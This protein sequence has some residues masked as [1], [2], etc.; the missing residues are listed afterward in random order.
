MPFMYYGYGFV[1]IGFLIALLAQWNVQ[2]TYSKYKKVQNARCL[3]G[4]MAA[5]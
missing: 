4:A 5:R 1:L 3:T 2:S